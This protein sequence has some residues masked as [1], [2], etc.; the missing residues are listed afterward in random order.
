MFVIYRR[1]TQKYATRKL[2][3]F[4]AEKFSC[5]PQISSTFIKCSVALTSP[6]C[7]CDRKLSI[8]SYF[9]FLRKTWWWNLFQY[10]NI[11]NEKKFI[12]LLKKMTF[13]QMAQTIYPILPERVKTIFPSSNNKHP[14]QCHIHPWTNGRN[15]LIHI[16]KNSVDSMIGF[17]A[18]GR[19]NHSRARSDN[20]KGFVN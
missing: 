3:K 20:A 1:I 16:P 18:E 12:E 10:I 2:I 7:P 14:R 17:N 9:E 13:N 8:L 6:T 19:L 4:R 15:F 11:V 5:I